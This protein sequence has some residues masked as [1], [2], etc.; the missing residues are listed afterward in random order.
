MGWLDDTVW[1]CCMERINHPEIALKEIDAV[2]PVEHDE[3]QELLLSSRL[4]GCDAE[5]EKILDLYRKNL[6]SIDDVTRQLDKVAKDK[7]AIQAE[8]A[9][10]R[11]RSVT[12]N[13]F[14]VK[15]S[16]RQIFDLIQKKLSSEELS[17]ELKRNVIRML[18]EKISIK[19]KNPG[20]RSQ[21]EITIYYK[22][23]HSVSTLPGYYPH[24]QTC[25]LQPGKI[26]SSVIYPLPE[27]AGKTIAERLHYIRLS[28]NLLLKDVAAAAGL[29][30][31][32]VGGIESGKHTHIGFETIIKLAA[33]ID[34]SPAWLAAFDSLPEVSCSEQLYK[35]RMI[36]MM[37]IKDAAAFIGVSISTYRKWEKGNSI[38]PAVKIEK[39][40]HDI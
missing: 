8:L 5:R 2:R 10:I 11:N 24:G 22:F 35:A 37:V 6:I 30:Y 36:R 16:A 20:P 26:T 3:S 7:S 13:V 28:R 25:E 27:T 29:S 18:V 39:F 21:S 9:A 1:N 12:N 40:I 34:V 38:P 32:T 4:S 19:T 23:G 14:A 17:F 33:S 15:E 31:N